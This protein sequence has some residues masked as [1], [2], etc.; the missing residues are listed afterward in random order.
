MFIF[1]PIMY[2]VYIFPRQHFKCVHL[3][4]DKRLV[5]SVNLPG[6]T[7][8]EI[9]SQYIYLNQQNLGLSFYSQVNLLNQISL[10]DSP[11]IKS[12][13]LHLALDVPSTLAHSDLSN[14]PSAHTAV[15]HV[16]TQ[17]PRAQQKQCA[18]VSRRT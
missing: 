10:G 14:V 4:Y 5:K 9:L 12:K 15:T 8:M 16:I 17:D 6:F 7:C 18:G 13:R 11:L 2:A 3:L 1:F